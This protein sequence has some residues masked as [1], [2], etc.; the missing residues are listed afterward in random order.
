MGLHWLFQD[1]GPDCCAGVLQA[2]G[3]GRLH[4]TTCHRT[5]DQLFPEILPF[6]FEIEIHFLGIVQQLALWNTLSGSQN[7]SHHSQHHLE[8]K[9]W[10]QVHVRLD[11]TLFRF[12]LASGPPQDGQV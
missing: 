11:S 10:L 9:S 3:L 8:E 12:A 7:M 5:D 6:P 4:T 2:G 1:Q